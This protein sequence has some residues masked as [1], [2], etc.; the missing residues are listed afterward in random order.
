MRIAG[1]ISLCLLKGKNF[2]DKLIYYLEEFKEICRII[3]KAV[4]NRQCMTGKVGLGASNII[5]MACELQL[6]S[7]FLLFEAHVHVQMS[8]ETLLNSY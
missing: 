2:F 4:I 3:S 6:K 7:S 8:V 5:S 1:I